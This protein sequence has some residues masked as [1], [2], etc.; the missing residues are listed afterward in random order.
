VILDHVDGLELPAEACKKRHNE[1]VQLDILCAGLQHLNEFVAAQ[2]ENMRAALARDPRVRPG[3]VVPEAVVR[4]AFDWYAVSACN[5]V[6]VIGWLLHEADASLPKPGV[7]VRRII[8]NVL[9]YRNKVAAHFA[10][11][12]PRNDGEATLS[13]STMPTLSWRDG[14]PVVG[15]W[16]V[17]TRSK[18]KVTQSPNWRWGLLETHTELGK[19]YWPKVTP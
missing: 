9:T 8:P 2:A 11:S 5:F 12:H 4:C 17:T 18:G 7:Y 13:A 19:R 10:R 3:R 6:H 16:Q 15:G 1:L 14:I